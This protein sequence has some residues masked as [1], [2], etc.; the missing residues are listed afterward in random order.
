M[1]SNPRHNFTDRT[2]VEKVLRGDTRAFGTIVGDTEK[3]V[4][5]IV[6]KMIPNAEDRKDL[7]QD[8]YI[9]A[10]KKLSGFKFESRL[11]TWIA[12]IGYNT[13]LDYLRKK[14]LAPDGPVYPREGER[15]G[16]HTDHLTGPVGMRVDTLLQQKDL[17][18]LLKME[19]EKLP[20][21]Y[22]TLI[23]LYHTE[24]LSYDEIGQITGLP[25]GTVKS[26]LFR[27]RRT[28]R[29]N[30]MEKYKKEDLW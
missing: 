23:G 28:L 10:Y 15:E 18:S 30:L 3:L 6:F 25:E 27:A 5:Q 7:A 9:K 4:A 24:D 13:C 21:V 2:L 26:Y 16:D 29:N 1:N 12:R 22:K 20:P 8:I 17:S 11:S 14:K 19:T